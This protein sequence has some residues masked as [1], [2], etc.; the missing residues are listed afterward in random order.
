[1]NSLAYMNLESE[2]H[3][4]EKMIAEAPESAIIGRMSLEAR[5]QSVREELDAMSSSPQSTV[6]E[7]PADSDV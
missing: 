6:C 3:A 1:M 2:I 7:Q 5:L 4:L